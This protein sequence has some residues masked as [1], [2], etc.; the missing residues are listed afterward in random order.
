MAKRSPHSYKKWQK[1]TKR[2]RK[3]QEKT[4][5]RQGK[6]NQADDADNPGSAVGNVERLKEGAE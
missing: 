4:A 2:K 1:E 3:A 6:K 5:R